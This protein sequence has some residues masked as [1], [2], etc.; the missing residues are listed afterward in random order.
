MFSAGLLRV[1]QTPPKV[2]RA[3]AGRSSA[4][5]LRCG[6]AFERL[7][8]A[9]IKPLTGLQGSRANPTPTLSATE[10]GLFRGKR[11]REIGE[12]QPHASNERRAPSLV[13]ARRQPCRRH[14]FRLRSSLFAFQLS[15]PRSGCAP[16]AG[17]D[18]PLLCPGPLCSGESGSTGR[19]AGIGMDA[20]AFSPAQGCAVE[21]PDPGSRTFRAG[22]PE[23]AEAGWPLFG[24]RFSG[25]TEK[26]GSAAKGRR[27]LL[28]LMTARHEESRKQDQKR[29]PPRPSPASRGGRTAWRRQLLNRSAY[30]DT[31]SRPQLAPPPPGSTTTGGCS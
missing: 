20:D 13:C 29:T 2:R 14:T 10:G 17:H 16:S 30:A 25:H 27:K 8:E 28:L 31:C 22:S 18:G 5:S 26:G 24:P 15:Q 19:A 7:L 12:A 23:S 3:F 11:G 4:T 1:K 9:E 6:L 21:K